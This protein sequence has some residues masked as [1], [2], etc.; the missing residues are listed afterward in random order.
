MSDSA[1]ATADVVELDLDPDLVIEEPPGNKEPYHLI[2][3][4]KAGSGEV[5]EAWCGLKL[6]FTAGTYKDFSMNPCK[7]C[8][9]NKQEHSDAVD[10]DKKT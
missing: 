7:A 6:A 2:R 9:K 3:F 4:G 5:A 8:V 1:T 10:G